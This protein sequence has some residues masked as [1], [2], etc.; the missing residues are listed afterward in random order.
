[1]R[2]VLRAVLAVVLAA[3][4]VAASIRYVFPEIAVGVALDI[5]RWKSGVVRRQVELPG[6]VRI[7]YLDGGVGEPL[8][9][10]HGF[11]ADKDSFTPI[12]RLLTP[13]FRVIVPD[14]VGFGESSRPAGADYSSAA[15]VAR[16]RDFGK[17]IGVASAHLGG[18]SMG[19]QI[20]MAWAAAHPGE[21][22]SLWLLD[23]AGIR[24]APESEFARTLRETGRNRLLVAS[25][26]EF[27]ELLGLTMSRPPT[28]PRIVQGVLARERIRNRAHEERIF[29]QLRVDSVE[30]RI[31]FLKV[32]TLAVF[33]AED[34][35]IDPRTAQVL[36]KLMPRAHV[37]V[38]PG[39]GHLPALEAPQR[40][41]SDYIRFR[42]SM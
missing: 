30:A 32:A 21:V 7:A 23:P 11:G 22:R 1:M 13:Q 27:A 39:I 17:A 6:G 41:A 4:L 3:L 18:S 24:S 36:R 20:A 2:I 34:R 9:L 16:L 42:D 25:E 35:V 28:I 10:L 15:Q 33:G 5:E 14:L 40:T 8:L 19:G 12:A 29:A 37:V 26:A 31:P 38:M